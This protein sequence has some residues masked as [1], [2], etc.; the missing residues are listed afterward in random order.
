MKKVLSYSFIKTLPVACGYLFLGIAFGIL[1][2]AAGYNAF[3]S[4]CCSI[5]IY[6]GSMQ[7]VLVS[8]LT[9]GAPLATV[10]VM[11][12]FI[13]GRHI[14]Y[15]LGFIEK[16]RKMGRK[17]PYMVLSLTDE[18][19]SLLCSPFPADIDESRASFIIA[20]LDHS[21]WVLGSFLGGILGQALPFDFTGID[22]S[23]TALFTVIFIEQWKASKTHIPAM[24][25]AGTALV[26]LVVLGA[27]KFLLPTVCVTVAILAVFKQALE[28]RLGGE[29]A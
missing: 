22:F 14:F 5:F 24:I 20:L 10:A 28:P 15:G 26:F 7:F 23:M 13:N 27:D 2:S 19:Y 25:G 12:L 3:W 18:T 16:F 1:M 9:A 29:A 6:G 4:L 17:Y 21:Y 11:T 8:L